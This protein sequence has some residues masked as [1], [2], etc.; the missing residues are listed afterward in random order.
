MALKKC[1]F[2][3]KITDRKIVLF[4][5]K[6]LKKFQELL[7]IRKLHRLKY[8]EVVLPTEPNDTCGYHACCYR[9]FSAIQKKY[10]DRTYPERSSALFE[11][12]QMAQPFTSTG[13]IQLYLSERE[14]TE[15]VAISEVDIEPQVSFEEIKSTSFAEPPDFHRIKEE[16]INS[17]ISFEDTMP[18]VFNADRESLIFF[19]GTESLNLAQLK[20][21]GTAL[22]EKRKC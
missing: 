13:N 21:F 12:V 5:N 17:S 2:C 22:V 9:P 7:M 6:T 11:N 1:V 4:N 19:E 20:K 3:D 14:I 8:S 18:L 15:A 10:Y 16:D